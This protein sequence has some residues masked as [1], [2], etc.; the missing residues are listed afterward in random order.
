MKNATYFG[1]FVNGDG[2]PVAVDV[3]S[4]TNPRYR[5]IHAKRRTARR[6]DLLSCPQIDGSATGKVS[7]NKLSKFRRVEL[8]SRGRVRT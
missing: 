1:V 7:G 5:R 8:S 4:G 6:G 2:G 3:I